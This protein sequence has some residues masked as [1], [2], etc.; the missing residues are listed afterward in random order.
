MAEPHLRLHRKRHKS[1]TTEAETFL[2]SAL[3]DMRQGS[4]DPEIVTVDK[5][6]IWT[7]FTNKNLLSTVP[8]ANTSIEDIASDDGKDED[9]EDLLESNDPQMSEDIDD[10]NAKF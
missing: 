6:S 7:D 3:V 2:C 1:I 4:M 10:S 5:G 9:I 8:R